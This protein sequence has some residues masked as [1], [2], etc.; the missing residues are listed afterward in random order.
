M[1]ERK[2]K[3]G[4]GLRLR[5]TS[6]TMLVL[7]PVKLY[8]VLGLYSMHWVT[9]KRNVNAFRQQSMQLSV[10]C[11]WSDMLGGVRCS[12]WEHTQPTRLKCLKEGRDSINQTTLHA[13]VKHNTYIGKGVNNLQGDVEASSILAIALF[14]GHS[15]CPVFD[16]LQY[17]NCN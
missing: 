15:H 16:R 3:F 17:A 12:T 7:P 4:Q 14:Q 6:Y 9:A 2:S 8:L 13:A 11:I 5:V 1:G 10:M